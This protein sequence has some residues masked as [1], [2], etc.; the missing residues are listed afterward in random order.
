MIRIAPLRAAAG[1]G[2]LTALLCLASP[3]A[4]AQTATT[5]AGTVASPPI[6][7]PINSSDSLLTLVPFRPIAE[8]RQEI[9]ELT[10]RR[11]LFEVEE[12][13]GKLMQER[14]KT[15]IRL[16][17]SQIQ[18]IKANLDLAKKEKNELVAAEWESKKK[19]AELEKNL[20]ERREAV[21]GKEIAYSKASREFSDVSIECRNLELALAG[22]RDERASIAGRALSAEVVAALQRVDHDLDDLQKRTLDGQ[23]K[24]AESR[25]NVAS[26]EVELAKNRKQVLEAQI[27]LMRGN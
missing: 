7:A 2:F 12:Q 1:L 14:A 5:P 3:A 25:K 20:L 8:I 26:K 9:E 18:T 13:N 27:K 21:R 15:E 10:A 16:K 23:I 22:K 11:N 4:R 17:E 24:A 6:S 19:L